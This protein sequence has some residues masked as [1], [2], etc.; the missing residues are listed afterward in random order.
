MVNSTAINTQPTYHQ[1]TF[2]S[3]DGGAP[4]FRSKKRAC[5]RQ[6]KRRAGRAEV[7]DPG[8]VK[9]SAVPRLATKTLRLKSQ[10]S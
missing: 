4:A 7:R 6:E 2:E 10:V 5:A 1:I 9:N 3:A 8:G